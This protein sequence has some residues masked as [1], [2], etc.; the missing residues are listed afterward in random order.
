M[1]R[2]CELIYSIDVIFFCYLNKMQNLKTSS[3]MQIFGHVANSP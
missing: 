1:D 2:Y 3:D